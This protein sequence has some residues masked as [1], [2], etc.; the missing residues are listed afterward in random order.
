VDHDNSLTM[1]MKCLGYTIE[2]AAVVLGCNADAVEAL[3]VAP[4]F[5]RRRAERELRVAARMALDVFR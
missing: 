1:T 3:A 4:E 5:E 2:T